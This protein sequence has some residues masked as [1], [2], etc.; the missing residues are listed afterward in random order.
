MKKKIFNLSLVLILIASV[1]FLLTGCNDKKSDDDDDESSSSSAEGTIKAFYKAMNDH[2]VDKMLKYIDIELLE[3]LSGENIDK[4][5]VKEYLNDFFDENEDFEAKVKKVTI[6]KD[7]DDM[8]EDM[9]SSGE[10][11]SYEEFVEDGEDQ[12]GVKNIDVYTVKVD[13]SD[14]FDYYADSD[15]KKDMAIVQKTDGKYKIIYTMS[16]Q[17]IISDSIYDYDDDYDS[18]YDDDAE[19][20]EFNSKYEKYEG[21]SITGKEVKELIDKVITNNEEDEDFENPIYITTYDEEGYLDV[22]MAS[23]T[24]ELEDIKSEIIATHEYEVE[25]EEGISGRVRYIDVKY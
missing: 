11:D 7:D 1:L 19:V 15:S 2:D 8:M 12:L 17:G 6:L 25:Y 4:E 24:S 20:E 23:T 10:Y 22:S 5:E 9:T 16:L 13:F 14:E 18:D 3:E 21:D